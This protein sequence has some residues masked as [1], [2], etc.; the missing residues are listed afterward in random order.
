MDKF[1]AL[2]EPNRR[3]ILELIAKQGAMSA[4]EI[5]NQFAISAPAISQHLKVLREANL[6]SIEKRAQSRIYTLKTDGF[7]DLWQW[8]T[9]MRQFWNDNF[10]RLDAVLKK[11]EKNNGK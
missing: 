3:R 2:A 6:V 4:T 5:G 11:V 7:D 10:D 1:A 9:Q 8:L